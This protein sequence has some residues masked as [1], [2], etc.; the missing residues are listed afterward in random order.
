MILL[1]IRLFHSTIKRGCVT[2]QV[3]GV[4]KPND[5]CSR[6]CDESDRCNDICYDDSC[7]DGLT[8]E[9]LA[10]KLQFGYLWD[11]LFPT[12][13]INVDSITFILFVYLFYLLWA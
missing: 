8:G 1:Q 4:C 5:K 3:K 6:Y 7:G 11:G 12:L 10:V 2:S 13:D 9:V